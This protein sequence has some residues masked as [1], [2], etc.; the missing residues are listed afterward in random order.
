MP[1]FKVPNHWSLQERLEH[2]SIPEPN[3]GC[4]LWDGRRDWNGYGM[5]A[6]RGQVLMAHRAAFMCAHGPIPRGR[7]IC[8]RCDVRACINPDHLFLGTH[9]D[10][11]VD[12]RAKWRRANP[13]A[14][15]GIKLDAERVAAVRRARGT[16]REIAARF[17]ISQT[18]VSKIKL[19]RC[20][21]RRRPIE[22]T[23]PPVSPSRRWRVELQPIAESNPA[24]YI[25]TVDEL[26]DWSTALARQCKKF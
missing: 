15:H 9:G 5:V 18:Q 2:F 20:W 16:Q 12:M 7:V 11:M 17:G 6:W 25:V 3:S 22:T 1:R 26:P 4:M 21:R 13:D 19:G 8:H 10:N 23:R 24:M 14:P